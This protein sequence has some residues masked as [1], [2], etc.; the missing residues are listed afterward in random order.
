MP[1]GF[2]RQ[3]GGPAHGLTEADD[4]KKELQSTAQP[5]G[6]MIKSRTTEH[7]QHSVIQAPR[8]GWTE[9]QI[10]KSG[11]VKTLDH[12]KKRCDPTVEPHRIGAKSAGAEVLT[13]EGTDNSLSCQFGGAHRNEDPC[14]KDRVDETGRIANGQVT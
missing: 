7:P 9:E 13:T 3:T 8:G 11:L 1:A 5:Q 14:R 12:S 2:D 6:L 10:E 4:G